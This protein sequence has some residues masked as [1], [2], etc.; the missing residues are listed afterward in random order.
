M[1][2]NRAC[3][4]T[5]VMSRRCILTAAPATV[6][7]IVPLYRDW[8]AARQEWSRLAAL[9]QHEH[10]DTKEM[11]DTEKHMLALFQQII[12]MTPVTGDGIA[13]ITHILWEIEGPDH[14]PG[15]AS[16]DAECNN[17]GNKLIRAIWRATSGCD[18]IPM[19]T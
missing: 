5:P 10:F 6:D 3:A 7:P 19:I 16:F 11:V 4:N 8:W 17:P 14:A 18:Q 2:N 9:P 13:A 1:P 15:T 12:E